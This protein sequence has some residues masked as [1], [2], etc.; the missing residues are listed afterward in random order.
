MGL[1]IDCHIIGVKLQ[2]EFMKGVSK[3]GYMKELA[4]QSHGHND[5]FTIEDSKR[6]IVNPYVGCRVRVE[7]LK[8]W[9]GKPA[10]FVIEAILNGHFALAGGHWLAKLW[11]MEFMVRRKYHAPGQKIGLVWKFS[12]QTL[13]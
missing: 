10:G 8:Q 6:G 3:M 1:Y 2:P 13:I 4:I 11:L 9:G 12:N 5:I 7:W